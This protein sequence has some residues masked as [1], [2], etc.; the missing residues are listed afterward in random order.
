MGC[1]EGAFV[2]VWSVVTENDAWTKVQI[3]FSHKNKDIG[4]YIDA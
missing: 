4:E 3:S 2:T 1:G